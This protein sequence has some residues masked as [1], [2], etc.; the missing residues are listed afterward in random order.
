MRLVGAFLL[1][2]LLVLIP[3]LVFGD[4]ME[5]LFAGDGATRWLR[6]WGDWAWAVACLLLLADLVIP[7]P[8]TA[9]LAALGLIYGPW[10]G[11]WIGGLGATGSGWL[12]YGLCRAMGR[13]T[14]LWLLGPRDYRRGHRLF[15]QVG[16]WVVLLSRWMPMLPEVVACMAGLTRMPCRPFLVASACGSFPL[17]FAFAWVGHA[18]SD[19]P[20]LALIVS[21]LLPPCLWYLTHMRFRKILHPT[22]PSRKGDL[23]SLPSDATNR[24]T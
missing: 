13:R 4:Q 7:L 21:M 15:T 14:A 24:E 5:A 18:G 3:F 11:G 17:A 20:A 6:S 19:R 2:A 23:P 22:V 12:A 8:G 1:A 16:T 10:L 9:I